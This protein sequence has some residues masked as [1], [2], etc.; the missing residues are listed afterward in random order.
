MDVALAGSSPRGRGKPGR[1]GGDRGHRGLIPA[2]AGKTA[3]PP[4]WT[5][6]QRAHPRAGGENGAAFP[7]DLLPVGSSPRGRGK[8]EDLR[9]ESP[10]HGLIPARAGKT[11]NIGSG[12]EHD[13][14]HPRAGGENRRADRSPGLAWGSS[15]RGRGKRYRARALF[16][17]FGL[18]PARAG[19]T[20]PDGCSRPP[21]PA[22]PRA[23]GENVV[24]FFAASAVQGSS[25]RGRGKHGGGRGLSRTVGLIPARAGKTRP[26]RSSHRSYRAHPR[27]GGENQIASAKTTLRRGSSPRGR[28]KR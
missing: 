22:H 15:P 19:K 23:G 5:S 27:A 25:P 9:P 2:R 24:C 21:A 16:A 10:I 26:R 11:G 28:G 13:G 3:N 7:R 4:E 17:V 12:G 18:I 1:L 8:H 20:E 6:H 14:A